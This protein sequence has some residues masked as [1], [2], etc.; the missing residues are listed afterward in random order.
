LQLVADSVTHCWSCQS[1]GEHYSIIINI[2]GGGKEIEKEKKCKIIT[3]AAV[4]YHTDFDSFYNIKFYTVH[5]GMLLY[6]IS[7]GNYEKYIPCL[8][9]TL[10]YGSEKENN[11]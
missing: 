4:S 10:L 5:H 7:M 8:S 1:F 6:F 3:S 2:D 11:V 9:I